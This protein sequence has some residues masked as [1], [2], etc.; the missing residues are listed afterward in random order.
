MLQSASV[1]S[2][3]KEQNVERFRFRLR[4]ELAQQL[5]PQSAEDPLGAASV[6]HDMQVEIEGDS[7][8]HPPTTSAEQHSMLGLSQTDVVNGQQ[9]TLE[10]PLTD[11]QLVEAEGKRSCWRV[12]AVPGWF[13]VSLAW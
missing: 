9:V 2:F 6:A 13:V 7:L 3:S 12:G 5:Q 11:P 8:Q 4:Y 10:E 1:K